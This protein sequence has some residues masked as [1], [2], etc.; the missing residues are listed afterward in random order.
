MVVIIKLIIKKIQLALNKLIGIY[1]EIH[2]NKKNNLV[3]S[4]Y[5]SLGSVRFFFLIIEL[6][7]FL[8]L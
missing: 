3:K 6:L 8:L 5:I 1:S 4:L 7:Q 2:L